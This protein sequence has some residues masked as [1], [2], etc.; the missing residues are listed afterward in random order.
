MEC[1]MP[2]FKLHKDELTDGL[3]VYTDRIQNDLNGFFSDVKASEYFPKQAQL[4]EAK[5]TLASRLF[6]LNRLND[7][8]E[9]TINVARNGDQLSISCMDQDI[10][11]HYTLSHSTTVS[12]E[13]SSLNRMADVVDEVEE[14]M[15]SAEGLKTANWV[16]FNGNPNLDVRSG[17]FIDLGD[18]PSDRDF[19]PALLTNNEFVLSA[20]AVRGLT[21]ALSVPHNSRVLEYLNNAWAQRGK[22]V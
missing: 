16:S 3:K 8:S 10:E 15:Q 14:A 7:E 13:N 9:L 1:L 22:N 17:G 5:S 18:T 20:A 2:K 11:L 4:A 6:K 12:G 21:N 19:V